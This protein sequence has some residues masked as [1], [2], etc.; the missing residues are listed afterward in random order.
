MDQNSKLLEEQKV[1]MEIKKN[2]K[3]F[4]DTL[5]HCKKGI[6]KESLNIDKC[7]ERMRSQLTSE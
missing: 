1:I 3:Q 7:V 6:F 5:L 2:F 4:I